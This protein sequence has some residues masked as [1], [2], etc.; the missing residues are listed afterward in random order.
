MMVLKATAALSVAAALLA[1]SPSLRAGMVETAGGIFEGEIS[2]HADAVKV[3]GKQIPLADVLYLRA[4]SAPAVPAEGDPVQL[5]H[6]NNGEVLAGE[7]VTGSEKK[8]DVRCKWFGLKAFA[9]DQVSVLEFMPGEPQADTAKAKTLYRK[10]AQAIP[11]TLVWI[12]KDTVGI[13]SPLGTAKIPR[14]G[15][16]RYVIDDKSPASAA[17]ID[18][19]GLV[20]GNLFRGKLK[21]EEGKVNL[22]HPVVGAMSFPAVAVRSIVR[23]ATTMIELSAL[24]HEIVEKGAAG[25]A[26]GEMGT[27][28]VARGAGFVRAT[29]IEPRIKIRYTQPERAGKKLLLRA[30]LAPVELARGDTRVTI[31]VGAQTVFDKTLSPSDGPQAIEVQIPAG[32]QFDLAVDFGPLLRFP[33]GA[34]VQDAHLIVAN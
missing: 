9:F 3:G 15:L 2:F 29:R 13:D 4:D 31:S 27:V 33:C 34:V 30:T 18:E 21:V 16:V 7:I 26:A 23:H 12:D 6:L 24:P 10:T 32:E 17:E 20:D 28:R 22:E 1:V 11:G 25:L 8:V 14:L 19:V 5:V